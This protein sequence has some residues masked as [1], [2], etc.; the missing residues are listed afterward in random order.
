MAQADAQGILFETVHRRK[1]GSTFPWKSAPRAQPSTA[2]A[3]SSAS[4]ATFPSAEMQRQ[5]FSASPD[6]P[7][8]TPTP[9]C[10]PVTRG[11]CFTPTSLHYA[12]MEPMGWR[13]GSPLPESLLIPIQR[14]LESRPV[15]GDRAD[16]P[17]RKGLVPHPA[18]QCQRETC[19]PLCPRHHGTKE[20][21]TGRCAK[22]RSD[23]GSWPMPCRNWCGPPPRTAGW[24]TSTVASGNLS[25]S[26]K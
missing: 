14:R 10:A 9:S 22:A 11:H 19:H 2:R 4:F 23:S 12:M 20:G 21:R 15:P 18:A 17:A 6:T 13:E 16:L 24:T 8:K 5:R 1:D 26:S 25:A 7:R 3:L